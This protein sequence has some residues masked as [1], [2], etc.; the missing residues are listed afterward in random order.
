MLGYNN[1]VVKFAMNKY[2]LLIANNRITMAKLSTA[3]GAL[4]PPQWNL[5][6]GSYYYFFMRVQLFIFSN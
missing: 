3:R 4:A 1:A 2:L 5:K 6:N